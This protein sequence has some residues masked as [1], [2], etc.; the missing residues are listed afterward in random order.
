M[1]TIFTPTYNRVHTIKR[2]YDSLCNQDCLDFEWIVVDDGSS[3]NT[4]LFFD[5]IKDSPFKI[6]YFY[7]VNE[8]K[9]RAINFGI[10]HAEGEWIMIVDSDDLLTSNAISVIKQYTNSIVNDDRFCG[11]TG[12][13]VDLNH[14]TIGTECNYDVLDTDSISYRT[15]YKI[16]GDRAEVFR[17]S[18]LK[19]YPFPEIKGEKFCTE[20]IVWNRIANK[21]ITR[22]INN[23]F[24]VC[25]YQID[26]LSSK[27]WKLMD[28]NPISSML[29]YKEFM[30]YKQVPF[31]YKIINYSYYKHYKNL[32]NKK[33][34]IEYNLRLPFKTECI[35][36]LFIQPL[37]LYL[38]II[39]FIK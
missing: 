2:L 11:I 14:N 21:Y 36:N 6:K 25:E 5:T 38:H 35:Y 19:Q 7:K 26:G 3:D 12:L 10:K 24:Y 28:E 31:K 8:G 22:Y 20:A 39:K 27:Y 4:K 16:E 18:I 23:G 9:H 30:L 15:K 33:D 32:V 1:I 13:R 34:I 29:Y 17:T 37:K